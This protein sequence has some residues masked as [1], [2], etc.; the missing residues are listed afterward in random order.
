MF[1][2]EITKLL[3][4]MKIQFDF[5][6]TYI[7]ILTSILFLQVDWDDFKNKGCNHL[8]QPSK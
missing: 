7:F 5:N 3:I 1:D 4:S 2:G 8:L 6:Y